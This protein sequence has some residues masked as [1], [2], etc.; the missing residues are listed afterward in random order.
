MVRTIL[1]FDICAVEMLLTTLIFAYLSVFKL[2]TSLEIERRFT[3]MIDA[4]KE[5]CFYENVMKDHYLE[6]NYEVS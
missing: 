6:A 1:C 3:V 4:Q 5:D 2:C